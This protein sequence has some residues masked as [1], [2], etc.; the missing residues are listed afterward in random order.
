MQNRAARIFSHLFYEVRSSVLLDELGG[1]R[2][3][4]VMAVI[5]P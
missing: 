5:N 1:E 3:E 4:T 2:L